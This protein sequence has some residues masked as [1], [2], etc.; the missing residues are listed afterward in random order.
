M[1]YGKFVNTEELVQAA[2]KSSVKF[3]LNQGCT[4]VT[5]AFNP[6]SGKGGTAGEGVDIAFQVPNREK[7]MSVRYFP[8]NKAFDKDNRE[9]TDPNHPDFQ[10][11]VEQLNGTLID[12]AVAVAGK[13]TVEAALQTNIPD[14]KAFITLLERVIKSVPAWEQKPLDLFLAYQYNIQGTNKR[15]FLELPQKPS[16][17]KHGRWVIAAVNGEFTRVKDIEEVKF[18]TSEGILHPFQRSSW[19]GSKNFSHPTIL[20]GGEDEAT[21]NAPED[22]AAGATS[23]GW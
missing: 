9:I 20:E 10:V 21:D 16:M 17:I 8:V 4:L 13:D 23:T 6:N 22:N 2:G 7:P 14:F 19:F 5:F 12:I 15:T 11:A 3:G 18:A 1:S